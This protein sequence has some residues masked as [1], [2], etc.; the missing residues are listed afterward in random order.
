[1]ENVIVIIIVSAAAVTVGRALYRSV[2][3]G[4]NANTCGGECT[5][6]PFRQIEPEPLAG[7]GGATPAGDRSG[8]VVTSR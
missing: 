4:K 6:C 8:T 1:M 5:A 3:G 2:A 7:D